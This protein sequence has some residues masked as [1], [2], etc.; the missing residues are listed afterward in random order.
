MYIRVTF[1]GNLV[2]VLI[3]VNSVTIFLGLLVTDGSYEN[4]DIAPATVELLNKIN[5]FFVYLFIGELVMKVL[6]H[7]PVSYFWD[8]MNIMDAVLVTISCYELYM[9]EDWDSSSSLDPMVAK[10]ISYTRLIRIVRAF[11]AIAQDDVSS[12]RCNHSH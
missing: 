8:F 3:L 6:S 5:I 4:M 9:L 10:I 11:A 7:G 1:S 12:S 2:M